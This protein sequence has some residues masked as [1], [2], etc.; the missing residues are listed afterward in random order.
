MSLSPTD[1]LRKFPLEAP[2][3]W[4]VNSVH[5]KYLFR[6]CQAHRSLPCKGGSPGGILLFPLL[7]PLQKWSYRGDNED[8]HPSVPL[9]PLWWCSFLCVRAGDSAA[10]L[11]WLSQRWQG[12]LGWPKQDFQPR[13][14]PPSLGL[15]RAQI[16]LL[17]ASHRAN[18]LGPLHAHEHGRNGIV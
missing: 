6:S 9:V 14:L 1:L 2:P 5:Q 4:Q 8:S 15:K 17:A 16:F 11:P 13:G 18:Y 7:L 3:R 10:A 12:N